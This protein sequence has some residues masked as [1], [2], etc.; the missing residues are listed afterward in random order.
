MAA[1][2][3]LSSGSAREPVV[4]EPAASSTADRETAARETADR[5]TANPE[6]GLA[7]P[8][9]SVPVAPE[10]AERATGESAIAVPDTIPELQTA[11]DSTNAVPDPVPDPQTA[12]DSTNAVPDPVPDFQPEEDGPAGHT[13]KSRDPALLA[14]AAIVACLVALVGALAIVTHGFRP[15]TVLTYR[16]AAVFSLR[17][18]DCINSSPNGLSVT[19]LSC[20]TPHDA[21]VFATFRLTGSSWPGAAAVQKESGSAC[22]SRIGGYLNPQFANA[23]FAQ[24]YVYPDQ[25]A[26]QAGVRTVVCEVRPPTGQVTGSV[27]KGS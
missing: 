17:A 20:A 14:V 22:A 16:P 13:G 5:E 25:Q 27:R 26:W 23:G 9:A 11:R 8:A 2:A 4:P 24:E 3:G 1:A 12:G 7:E 10:P 19:V 15:K 18:G 6:A 21:E